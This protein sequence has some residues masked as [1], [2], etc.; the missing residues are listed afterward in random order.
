MRDVSRTRN[1]EDR[2]SN[3]KGMIYVIHSFFQK[4]ATMKFLYCT[5]TKMPKKIMDT[6]KYTGGKESFS[7]LALR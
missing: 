7:A 6:T 1:G 3:T 2:F 4:N 5:F